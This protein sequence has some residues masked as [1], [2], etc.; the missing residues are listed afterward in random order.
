MAKLIALTGTSICGFISHILTCIDTK[1][2]PLSEFVVVVLGCSFRRK[3]HWIYWNE[4]FCRSLLT[5]DC[6]LC[7]ISIQKRIHEI[8]LEFELVCWCI[9]V[10]KQYVL[11]LKHYLMFLWLKLI[12]SKFTNAHLVLKMICN[13]FSQNWRKVVSNYLLQ[14]K[15]ICVIYFDKLYSKMLKIKV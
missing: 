10:Q 4:T 8:L 6:M 14:Y 7:I 3:Q 11:L 15:R 2:W 13:G 9:N 12:F 5:D 1:I